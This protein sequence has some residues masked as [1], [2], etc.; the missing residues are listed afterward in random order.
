MDITDSYHIYGSYFNEFQERFLK[1]IQKRS[2]EERT[3]RTDDPRVSAAI[4]YGKQLLEK[5]RKPE[6]D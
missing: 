5:E 3:W 4:A 2:F 1:I 6:T